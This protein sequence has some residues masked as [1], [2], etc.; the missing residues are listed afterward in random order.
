MSQTV[1]NV[2]LN[3]RPTED[4]IIFE[5]GDSQD[6]TEQRCFFSKQKNKK[7]DSEFPVLETGQT[8]VITPQTSSCERGRL[9][10]TKTPM[11]PLILL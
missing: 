2:H 3:D 9:H 4:E 8:T 7:V 6:I 5:N 10:G 1:K 11:L